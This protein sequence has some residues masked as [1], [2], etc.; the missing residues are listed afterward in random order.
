MITNDR[1][2]ERKSQKPPRGKR[3]RKNEE[4]QPS[5]TIGNIPLNSRWY[6]G[7][8]SSGCMR[9][10]GVFTPPCIGLLGLTDI[11]HE[12]LEEEEEFASSFFSSFPFFQ[13]TY[14]TTF[15]IGGETTVR[16]AKEFSLSLSL[17]HSLFHGASGM[18]NKETRFLF[19]S[20]FLSLFQI[21]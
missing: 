14:C 15:W 3:R 21:L 5:H 19:I 18:L 10:K 9:F 6:L 13:F 8:C 11:E 7:G 4:L 12:G 16:D 20:L 2:G 17:S 1:K